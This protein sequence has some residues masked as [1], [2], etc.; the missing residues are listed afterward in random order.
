MG[1][2]VPAR[3]A[4]L[5]PG[6]QPKVILCFHLGR[7]EEARVWLGRLLEIVPALTLDGFKVLFPPGLLP[8][9]IMALCV[10]AL[11]KAGLPEA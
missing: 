8:P 9:E 1:G 4:A 11:H 5:S 7:L 6:D 2:P 3:A 10:G